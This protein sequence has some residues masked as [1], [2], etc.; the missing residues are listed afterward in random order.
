MNWILILF[1][2]GLGNNRVALETIPMRTEQG[3]YEAGNKFKKEIYKDVNQV[4]FV[5]VEKK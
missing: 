2:T 1:V 5:C 4:R 3:C